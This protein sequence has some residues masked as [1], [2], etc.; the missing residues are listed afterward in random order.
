MGLETSETT[1]NINNAFASGT[2]NVVQCSGGLRRLAKE[3]GAL[4]MS[5]IAGH[6]KLT[7]TIESHH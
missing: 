1:C 3:T 6:W 2:S 4:K 5:I 7:V